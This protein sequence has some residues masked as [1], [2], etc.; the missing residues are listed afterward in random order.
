MIFKCS[1]I[2][3]V[4]VRLIGEFLHVSICNAQRTAASAPLRGA[5]TKG[6]IKPIGPDFP[7]VHPKAS[8]ESLVATT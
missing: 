2:C 1:A 7:K 5:V 4:L 3:P 6:P 8:L